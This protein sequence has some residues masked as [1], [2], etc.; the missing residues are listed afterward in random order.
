MK[1]RLTPDFLNKVRDAISTTRKVLTENKQYR[2]NLMHQITDLKGEIRRVENLSSHAQTAQIDPANFLRAEIIRRQ[3]KLQE[4][5]QDLLA[6]EI[7]HQ[8]ERSKFRILHNYLDLF[9]FP[10]DPTRKGQ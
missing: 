7:F 4:L 5:R 9:N 8:I 6:A 10:V 1:I 3:R 2:K